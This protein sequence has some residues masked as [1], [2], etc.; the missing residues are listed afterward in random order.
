[1]TSHIQ[2]QPWKRGPWVGF[3]WRYDSGLVAGAVPFA[4]ASGIVDLAGS[5]LTAD[6]Q[7]QAGL[8]CNGVRATPTM[9]LPNTAWHRNSHRAWS[10]SQ[11]L[12]PRMMTTTLRESLRETSSI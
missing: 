1:M 2:Y 6:Q 7:F 8:V 10:K 4:D 5:G 9:A 3:N 11:R 12:A